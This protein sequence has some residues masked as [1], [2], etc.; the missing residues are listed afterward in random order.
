MKTLKKKENIKQK[1]SNQENENVKYITQD[2]S[3]RNILI[4]RQDKPLM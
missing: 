1:K 2:S 4:N 3:H